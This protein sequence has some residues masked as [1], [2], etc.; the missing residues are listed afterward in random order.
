MNVNAHDLSYT[1]NLY[2]N[3][4]V[5]PALPKYNCGT[6]IYTYVKHERPPRKKKQNSRTEMCIYA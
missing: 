4:Q 6:D 1:L 5:T 2:Q 3:M